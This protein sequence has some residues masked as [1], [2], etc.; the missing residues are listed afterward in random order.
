MRTGRGDGRI[1]RPCRSLWLAAVTST[2]L[3]IAQVPVL[4]EDPPVSGPD[5]PVAEQVEQT[6]EPT[7]EPTVQRDPDPEPEPEPRHESR[8]TPEPTPGPVVAATPEPTPELEAE[9]TREPAPEATPEPTSTPDASPEPSVELS[10]GPSAGPVE[11]S[12]ESSVEPSPESSVEPSPGLACVPGPDVD[13]D[14]SPDPSP[15][16]NLEPAPDPSIAPGCGPTREPA[17]SSEPSPT[18]RASIRT[19]NTDYAPGAL[20]IVV[21][22]GWRPG[23]SI[24]LAIN[25]DE[26]QSWQHRDTTAAGPDGSFQYEFRLPTWFVATYTITGTGIDS[27]EVR[28]RFDDSIGTGPTTVAHNGEPPASE[29]TIATPMAP[30]GRLL[31]ATIVVNALTTAQQICTPT[32]WTTAD[33]YRTR[34]GNNVTMKTFYRVS[35]GSD[36]ASYTW[37][38]RNN[39][40]NCASATAGLLTG[41]GAVG[42]ITAYAGVDVANAGG[43]MLS[44]KGGSAT[45]ATVNAPTVTGVAANSIVVRRF[46]NNGSSTVSTAA[47]SSTGTAYSQAYAVARPGGGAVGPGSASADTDQPTTG[48]V[49]TLT[50]SNGGAGGRWVAQTIVLRMLSSLPIIEL[51]LSD[52]TAQLGTNL[53]PSGV[54]SNSP[55]GV[56][57][58]VDPT[59]PSAGACYEWDASVTVR[60]TATY[61]V[62]VAAAA[63]NARLDFLTA[64][65]ATYAACTGGQGVA[66]A[67]F[68]SANP[69][70][71]WVTNQTATAGR[72]HTYWLGLAVLWTDS[73]NAALAHSTLTITA[74][75][76][77]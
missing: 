26:G 58:N 13:L 65:P 46:G 67:M 72:A 48:S 3:L 54:S 1:R 59:A 23:E 74:V 55:D 27:G 41:K 21:G 42:G 63:A 52:D 45:T 43:P 36:A 73:P 53:T 33:A 38:I 5:A 77:W 2:L 7:P 49:G 34:Q 10:P 69:P 9:R 6:P 64:D 29:I 51:T 61:N 47:T 35:T 71:A 75:V 18:G 16:P 25:D 50:A 20:V 30:A 14:I 11:P 39:T 8:P 28:W 22:D 19:N 44:L 66:A 15:R 37:R 76:D 32:G 4:A 31:L 12:P 60:S 17:P 57:V 40:A 24:E 62:T 70:G 56:A 68:T